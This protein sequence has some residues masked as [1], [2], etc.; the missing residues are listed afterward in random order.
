[1]IGIQVRYRGEIHVVIEVVE[2]P[3]ALVLKK[4]GETQDAK[5]QGD[6]LGYAHRRT[7][8]Q[9]VVELGDDAGEL[10]LS[11]AGVNVRHD[12]TSGA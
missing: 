5:I 10:D 3:P 7:P 11:A 6:S 9:E 12:A 8:H 2:Q 4:A 1:M